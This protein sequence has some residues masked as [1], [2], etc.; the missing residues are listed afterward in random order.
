MEG[1]RDR[2]MQLGDVRVQRWEELRQRSGAEPF[3]LPE[4]CAGTIAHMH[5]RADLEGGE[6]YK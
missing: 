5:L 3:I 2:E 6:D 4:G 1:S